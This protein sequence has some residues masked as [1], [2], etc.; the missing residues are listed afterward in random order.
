[1]VATIS[2]TASEVSTRSR[3]IHVSRLWKFVPS[4]PHWL[5]YKET[6]LCNRV[7][8]GAPTFSPSWRGLDIVENADGRLSEHRDQLLS[9]LAEL[10]VPLNAAINIGAVQYAVRDL[11]RTSIN[12]FHLKQ[13]EIEW[14]AVAYAR[15]LP[16]Q[17][18]WHNRLGEIYSFDELADELMKRP[19]NIGSCQGIHLVSSLTTILLC[20]QEVSFL[21]EDVR[22]RISLHLTR[23]VDMAVKTQQADGLWPLRWA[24]EGFFNDRGQFTPESSLS[25]RII[26]S[27][28][29]LE[30]FHWL[31]QK[32]KPPSSTLRSGLL[33]LAQQLDASPPELVVSNF[34]PYTHAI[35]ALFLAGSH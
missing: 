13:Q 26:V 24:P 15:Y 14:T 20:D 7:L 10:K 19:L 1:M 29:L 2:P 21:S 30:W 12:E 23:F 27:G 17:S 22:E 28:H 6:G 5:E 8:I 9:A 11:L 3:L 16:P 33:A 32:L 31:P 18:H 35:T 25:S 4:L 34:C